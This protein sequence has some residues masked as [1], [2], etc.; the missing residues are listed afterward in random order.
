MFL[1]VSEVTADAGGSTDI[2]GYL[3]SWRDEEPKRWNLPGVGSNS[4]HRPTRLAKVSNGYRSYLL[5]HLA[6]LWFSFR[7]GC[8]L[9]QLRGHY[10]H[11]D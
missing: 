4:T 6:Y 8:D 7:K 3:V 9:G 10:E 5:C 1:A 11:G 2:Q